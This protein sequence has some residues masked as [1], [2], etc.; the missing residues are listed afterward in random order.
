[1]RRSVQRGL[2]WLIVAAGCAGTC[3]EV[4]QLRPMI[5]VFGLSVALWVT[6]SAWLLD[7]MSWPVDEETTELPTRGER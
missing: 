4:L 2:A 3:Y 1:M 7:D 5:V 6:G